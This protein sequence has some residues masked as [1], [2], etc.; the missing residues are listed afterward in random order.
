MDLHDVA[1]DGNGSWG[2][3]PRTPERPLQQP[4]VRE[5]SALDPRE[6]A[7]RVEREVA[8]ILEEAARGAARVREQAA[9]AAREVLAGIGEARRE[10]DRIEERM[11]ALLARL[12]EAA[13]PRPA[14]PSPVVLH[15]EPAGGPVVGPFSRPAPTPSREDVVR[16]LRENLV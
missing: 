11:R 4:G 16:A 1:T 9:A 6:L 13:G 7:G 10:L 12:P 15:A 14:E 3:A 8:A 2:P 5:V